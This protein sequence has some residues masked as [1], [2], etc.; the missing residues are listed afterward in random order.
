MNRNALLLYLRDLRDLEFARRK[1]ATIYERVY[2]KRIISI[3]SVL[4]VSASLVS[5]SVYAE[6][7]TQLPIQNADSGENE[8]ETIEIS[9]YLDKY[10]ELVDK[11]QMDTTDWWQ[12][13]DDLDSYVK[14][15]FY[16]E[17]T[18]NAFSCKNE[19]ASY[20]KLYGSSLGDSISD[21]EKVLHKKG[22]LDYFSDDK[23][24]SY[25]TLIKDR[26]YLINLY[27]DEND[28]VDSW[29]LNNWPEGED[30]ADLLDELRNR[31]LSSDNAGT[32]G[33]NTT[34]SYMNG[35]FVSDFS[36]YETDG[37]K[38]AELMFWHNY[39]DSSS[40]EDFFFD[41][42]EGKLEYE[43]TGNRAQKRFRVNFTPIDTGV[44]IKVTCLD[45]AYFSWQTG[46]SA[47]VW[48]DE[49]YAEQ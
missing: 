13:P 11:L 45:G 29:Y 27:K 2:M 15:Q 24:C 1:I 8:E 20:I 16:L 33:E 5:V 39:G 31:N 3:V 46:Q 37:K 35:E 7:V 18:D 48:S 34:Y 14:D 36:I 25:I 47:E 26:G 38:K 9:S 44:R 49:E 22:W 23:E 41:W 30:V 40:D 32:V 6:D 42:E 21:I 43:L 19:G 4:L 17:W 10:Q 28:K 12:F